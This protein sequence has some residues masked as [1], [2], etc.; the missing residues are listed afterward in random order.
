M[1]VVR[2]SP[3]S[4]I[5]ARRGALARARARRRNAGAVM[6]I[7]AVTLGLLAV[8]GVYGLS[9]TSADI[10]SAGHMREAL[11]AQRAGDAALTMTAET[12]N[13]TIAQGLVT[14]MSLGQ[15]QARDCVTAAQPYTGNVE[16]RAAEACIRLDP[17]RMM[18][19]ANTSNP[20]TPNAWV[21]DPAPARP[22]FTEK[23]FGDVFSRPYINVEVTNPINTE[24]TA[25]N[26]QTVRYS[27]L[28]VTVFVQLKNVPLA[29][30]PLTTPAETVVAGRG[31]VTVGPNLAGGGQSSAF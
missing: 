22:G 8:M 11:Q 17:S 7:V 3:P 26:S 23:S 24:V 25:G 13:P 18:T 28:T 4:R 14:Q 6:F 19:I 31:R 2:R 30:N 10:R 20:L 21:A 16:T 29:G 15:G 9:A 12:F 27:Q 5:L 1:N